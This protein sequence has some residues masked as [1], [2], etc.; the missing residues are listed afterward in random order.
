MSERYVQVGETAMRDLKT[1]EF[2][3]SV[4]LFAL[5]ADVDEG[6]DDRMAEEIGGLLALKF[7]AYKDGCR[8]AGVRAV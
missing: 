8:K 6:A 5:E 3:R 2:L 7:R 4:P 1:G